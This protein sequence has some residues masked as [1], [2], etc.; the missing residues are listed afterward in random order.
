MVTPRTIEALVRDRDTD[1][2]GPRG[3]GVVCGDEAM[4]PNHA[5]RLEALGDHQ[6]LQHLI[7]PIRLVERVEACSEYL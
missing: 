4:T 1:V 5:P 7:G 3:A 6:V 2:A